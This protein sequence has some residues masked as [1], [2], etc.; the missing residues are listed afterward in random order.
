MT[1]FQFGHQW[2]HYKLDHIKVKFEY[3]CRNPT[4]HNALVH[5]T[6]FYVFCIYYVNV[7]VTCNLFVLKHGQGAISPP[8]P[9]PGYPP[10]FRAG[11][12]FFSWGEV[13]SVIPVKK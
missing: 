9:S 4:F 6:A 8:P 1:P 13:I 2:S 10:C 12:R 5:V 3:F 11:S 7:V